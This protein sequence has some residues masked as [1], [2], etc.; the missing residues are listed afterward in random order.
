ML[1]TDYDEVNG[2]YAYLYGAPFLSTEVQVINGSGNP[3]AVVNASS[4]PQAICFDWEGN[5]WVLDSFWEVQA[6]QAD[7]N[8]TEDPCI[9][10]T[11]DPLE[12]RVF[13]MAVNFRN[14]ALYVFAQGDDGLGQL[15]KLNYDGTV[16]GL[17]DPVFDPAVGYSTYGDLIIDNEGSA[18]LSD[19]RISV[20]G[21][22]ST[23]A[24]ARFDSEL[25]PAEQRWYS[26]WGIKAACI[27]PETDMV[28]ALESCCARYFDRY[29]APDDW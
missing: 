7:K 14:H 9:G 29:I 1:S 21:G 10:Y 27:L 12:G 15:L 26:F 2:N 23:G 20:F 18:D 13:D 4:A 6:Y 8:F 22:D 25:N 3:I 11:L 28:I 24:V 5:L 16:G 17:V 19:C